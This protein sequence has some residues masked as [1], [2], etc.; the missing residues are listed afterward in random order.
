[1]EHSV[2]DLSWMAWT[3]QT[4][5]FFVVIFLLL[6]GM[7]VWEFA[8]P[9][10]GPR[11]RHPRA[12][13]D[14]RRPPVHLAARQRLHSSCLAR[15]R[16]PEPLVG[17]RPLAH[18]RPRGVSMGVRH[19]R[20]WPAAGRRLGE[21]EEYPMRRLLL[22][23]VAA[24]A[25]MAPSASWA[26]MAAAEK[27]VDSEFQPS[28]LSREDQLKE[29]QWFIDAAKPFAGYEIN[30][31]SEG[32]PTH[33]YESTVAD[34]G[35]RGDHR[36]QGQPPDPRRRRGR[37]GGSDADADEP[38]SLRRLHQRLRPDRHAFAPAERRQPDRLDGGRGQG[39][40]H[41]RRSTSTTSSASRSP[42]GR[43]ASSGSCPT[44]SSPT[45]TGSARTG[46]TAR[47]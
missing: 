11:R 9:G 41:C 18:L 44:S 16:R 22:G 33:D 14:A 19:L 29:M 31:L 47:I 17:S 7:T 46:S 36:H 12:R 21:R 13:H 3:W 34:Q 37:A 15:A 5:T 24:F 45:S 30:V 38:Q 42:P 43:T 28:T 2:F 27:W 23:T 10:G 1:M 6:C 32:V 40:H 20:G 25:L 35:V 8:S 26:D 39:R 4:A